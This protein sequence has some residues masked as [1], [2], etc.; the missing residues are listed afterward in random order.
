MIDT[1]VNDKFAAMANTSYLELLNA[2]QE[3]YKHPKN[4][5]KL[6]VLD[7]LLSCFRPRDFDRE[8]ELAQVAIEWLEDH[9]P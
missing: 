8:L 3:C 6:A 2:L 7:T 1:T 9:R 4:M 5:W